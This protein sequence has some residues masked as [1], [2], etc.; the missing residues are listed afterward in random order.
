METRLIIAGLILLVGIIFILYISIRDGI[1]ASRYKKA[2]TVRGTVIDSRGT[3]ME[4]TSDNPEYKTIYETYYVS[5]TYHGKEL[6]GDIYTSEKGLKP[7]AGITLHIRN[8]KGKPEILSDLCRVRA[9][10]RLYAFIFIAV[11]LIL[12]YLIFFVR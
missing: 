11:F 3:K 5:Y 7:G 6:T 12:G 2:E 8:N 4:M 10:N 1:G 9:R